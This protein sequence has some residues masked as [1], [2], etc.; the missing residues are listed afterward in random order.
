MN[1]RLLLL[2]AFFALFGPLPY[3]SGGLIPQS[4][5]VNGEDSDYVDYAVKVVAFNGLTTQGSGSIISSRHVLTTA[6]LIYHNHN[7][8]IFYGSHLNSSL[9]RA[10][11]LDGV[12]HPDFDPVTL[13]NDIGILITVFNIGECSRQ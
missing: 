8:Q 1:G 5:I 9:K 11:I 4:R 13:E 10:D 2:V 12:P 7:I 6:N 3:V